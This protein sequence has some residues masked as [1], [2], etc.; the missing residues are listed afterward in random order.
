MWLV[1]ADRA[2]QY[3]ILVYEKKKKMLPR[4]HVTSSLK[5]QFTIKVQGAIFAYILS[6]N[7]LYIIL[8]P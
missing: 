3:N 6:I 8:F 7:T 1:M 2:G 5:V 4:Q